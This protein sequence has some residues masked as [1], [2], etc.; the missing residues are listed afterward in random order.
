MGSERDDAMK[1]I[2]SLCKRRGLIFQSSEIYGGLKGCWDYGP[3]GVELKRN[4]I[5]AWWE[6]TVTWRDDVVGIDSSILMNREVWTASG[7][8]KGFT[9]PLVDCKECKRRFRADDLE[10]EECPECGGELTEARQFN[11]MLKTFI[12]PVEDESSET[13]LRPETAQGIF[14]D[15]GTVQTTSRQKLPFG[16]AQTGK[17]FRNEITPRNFIFRT[18]EFSQME[19]EYFVYR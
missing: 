3:F 15:F 16:I 10:A 4:V 14:T 18:V 19:L 5:E 7:H 17:S 11:L 2:A 12:G 1:E 8:V 13:Y 9:D 6:S